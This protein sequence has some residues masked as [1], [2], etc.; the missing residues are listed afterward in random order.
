M[1]RAVSSQPPRRA[2][3][4][5]AKGEIQRRLQVT[6][7]AGKQNPS[8]QRRRW[9]LR[10]GKALSERKILTSL[11]EGKGGSFSSIV[12]E[13]GGEGKRLTTNVWIKMREETRD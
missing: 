1:A 3:G 6:A 4:A 12:S 11:K 2:A 5:V 9:T 8:G 13:G 7:R 10:E